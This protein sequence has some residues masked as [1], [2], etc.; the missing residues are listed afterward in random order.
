MDIGHHQQKHELFFVVMFFVSFFLCTWNQTFFP[1]LRGKI[2]QCS[3]PN[4]GGGGGTTTTTTLGTKATSSPALLFGTS[5]SNNMCCPWSRPSLCPPSG[6]QQ[7]IL[8]FFVSIKGTNL[9]GGVRALSSSRAGRESVNIA[10]W[11][12]E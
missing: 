1:L 5:P 10:G 2:L 3:P 12:E 8:G 9:R 7:H 4:N 6:G 11:D